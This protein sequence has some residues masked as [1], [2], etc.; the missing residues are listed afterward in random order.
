MA[1]YELVMDEAG[2]VKVL[3]GKPVYLVD[4]KEVAFDAAYTVGT[5]NRLNS[6]SKGHRL[7]AEEFEAKAKLF[8]GLDPEAARK[9]LETVANFKDKQYLEAGEVEKLK[10]ETAKAYEEK[11]TALQKQFEPVLAERDALNNDLVSL[12]KGNAFA[13]SKFIA[14]KIA[15]PTPMVEKFFADNFK[16]EGSNIVGYDGQGNK[17]Y[18]RERP[19]EIASFDEALGLLVESSPLRDSI[20]KGSGASGGGARGSGGANGSKSMSRAAF[21]G[22]SP[23]E[24][25]AHV[26]AGGTV[27]D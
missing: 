10:A 2:H 11:L 1:N 17:L 19:G 5:I 9:A 24:Q 18:S 21:T 4:G 26:K 23:A 3:E 12:R 8:D 20:L 27:T 15:V 6:E 25:M 22:M 16:V 7:R 13:A 14:D